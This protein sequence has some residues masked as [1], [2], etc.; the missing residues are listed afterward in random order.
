MPPV[1]QESGEQRALLEIGMPPEGQPL[2]HR[3]SD[4]AEMRAA[5]AALHPQRTH[6]AA[7]EAERGPQAVLLRRSDEV[8]EITLEYRIFFL[9][10]QE[11]SLIGQGRFEE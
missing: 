5:E 4:L 10:G 2:V 1:Q 7:A 6:L 8:R 9:R 3:A 11:V